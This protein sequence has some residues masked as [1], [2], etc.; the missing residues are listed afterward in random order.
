MLLLLTDGLE[1]ADATALR[2]HIATGCPRCAAYLAEADATLAYLPFALEPVKPSA[3]ARE[4]LLERIEAP[5]VEAPMKPRGTR[6]RSVILKMPLW[7]RRTL[8]AAVAACLTFVATV[9]LMRIANRSREQH[10]N[11]TINSLTMKVSASEQQVKALQGQNK[12]ANSTLDALYA[13]PR[14]ITLQGINQPKA[15]GR[16]MWNE[17]RGAWHFRAFNLEL[18]PPKDAYELWFVTPYGRKVPAATF[19]PDEQGNAYLVV[20]LPKDVGPVSAAEVTDEPAVG[21]FQPTGDVHLRGRMPL[22]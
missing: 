19:K 16:A 7:V 6:S 10:V 9:Q 15:F 8:P 11:S 18:L 2:T 13:S 22:E 1:P 20:T 14:L 21:T 12:A 17:S 5:I 4:K 3:A